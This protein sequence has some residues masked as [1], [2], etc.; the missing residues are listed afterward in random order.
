MRATSTV[1]AAQWFPDPDRARALVRAMASERVLLADVAGEKLVLQTGGAD[2]RLPALAGLLSNADARL[3]AHRAER[4][5]TVAR[6]GVFVKVLPPGR[7]EAVAIAHR[8]A[9][10][11]DAA[12]T[13]PPVLR[14][15]DRV[16]TLELGRV[17]GQALHELLGRPGAERHARAV[18]CALRRFHQCPRPLGGGYHGPREE[19]HVLASWLERLRPYEPELHAR[20]V[21]AARPVMAALATLS[22]PPAAVLHRD[23]H[24]KQI[25]LTPDQRVGL[26]DL[27]TL[28]PGDPALD[29]ANLLAHIRLRAL[30]DGLAASAAE[31]ARLAL[32]DGYGMSTV[33]Q[34]ARLAA[35]ERATEL[36][37]ACVYAFRPRW[38]GLASRL[39]DGD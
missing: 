20:A 34:R 6:P 31:P 10:G 28:V 27:D 1:V 4:R 2:R 22:G 12:V 14:A 15:D 38:D 30:Q 35:Y 17:P 16:G 11:R 33:G 5:A 32:L 13:V 25:F 39:V 18:G 7:V 21:A 36:R 24:D 3:V 23:L 29:L 9:G 19:A 37:L 8:S 26:I